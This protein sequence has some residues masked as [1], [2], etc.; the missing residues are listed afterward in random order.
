MEPFVMEIA[1]TAFAVES[2]FETTKVYCRDYLTNR[3][4]DLFVSV[5]REALLLEQEL[6]N[7]EADE[8]GLK[9]RKFTEPFLERSV[10]QRLIAE[11]LIEKQVLLMHGSTIAVDGKAYLFTASCGTGKSTHTRLWRE[12]FGDRAVMVNDDKPFLRFENGRVIACGSPWTGKHGLGENVLAPLKGICILTRGSENRIW[13]ITPDDAREMLLHQC[14][15]PEDD[16]ARVSYMLEQLMQI[17]PLWQMECT[18]DLEAARL[19]HD[20]MSAN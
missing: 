20:A 10:I 11:L 17:V 19:A 13:R 6:L 14:F 7:R 2:L 3:Q 9:R 5:S 4:P 16:D 12:V 18:K 1:G 15:Q 8:E